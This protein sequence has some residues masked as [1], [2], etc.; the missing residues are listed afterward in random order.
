MKRII[1]AAVAAVMAISLISFCIDAGADT[2]RSYEGAGVG[3]PIPYV[4][5]YTGELSS[6]S[7]VLLMDLETGN[8]LIEQNA[9]VRAYPASTTKIMTAVLLIENTDDD[10]WDT[11]IPP[12]EQANSNLSKKGSQCGLKPGDQPTRRDLL[13][14]IMLPSGCDCAYVVSNLIHD[15]RTRFRDRHE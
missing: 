9:D 1:C 4:P 8:V 13:Y 5:E 7:R 10:D 6:Q 15:E 12:I 11:P 14:G 2:G 3:T